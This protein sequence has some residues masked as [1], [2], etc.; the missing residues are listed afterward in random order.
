[1]KV[2]QSILHLVESNREATFRSRLEEEH[3]MLR[4]FPQPPSHVGVENCDQ[5]NE[6][7]P[8][9]C[10]QKFIASK[11]NCKWPWL[12]KYFYN[13]TLKNCET[14]EELKYYLNV[15]NKVL[16]GDLNSE[17]ENFGCLTKNCIEYSWMTRKLLEMKTEDLLRN[18]NTAPL[19]KL[20]KTGFTFTILS[21]EV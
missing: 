5:K 10:I 7:K 16:R 13:E 8:F 9:S 11:L 21:N 3:F 17:L 18:P 20:N 12:E 1:M 4:I 14:V 2:P 15:Y 19:V 6:Q